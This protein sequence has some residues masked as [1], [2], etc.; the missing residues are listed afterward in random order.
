[1]H[2]FS[3]WYLCPNFSNN[4]YVGSQLLISLKFARLS[5]NCQALSAA[6]DRPSAAPC[7]FF[8]P[9]FRSLQTWP[10]SRKRRT[11][12]RNSLF[13]VLGLRRPE[14]RGGAPGLDG[15]G[16]LPAAAAVAAAGGR[17]GAGRRGP[18]ATGVLFLPG[19]A[20]SDVSWQV[21]HI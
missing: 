3:S 12:S 7:S 5:L 9:G 2:F 14:Q 15:G 10:R 18:T 19:T 20:A 21:F 1:M 13:L 4:M 6:T 17:D 11:W 16:Q 8:L